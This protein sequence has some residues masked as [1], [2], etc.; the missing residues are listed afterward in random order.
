MVVTDMSETSKRT[1]ALAKLGLSY[2]VGMI[3]GP[4]LGG[5]IT[6]LLRWLAS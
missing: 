1:D 2:G 3:I 6:T 4:L 5:W